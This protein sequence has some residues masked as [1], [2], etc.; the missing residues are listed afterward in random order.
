MV[1]GQ[2]FYHGTS[3]RGLKTIEPP[4]KTGVIQEISRKKNLNRVFFTAD[5]KMASIYAGRAARVYG[6]KG[7]SYT[8]K[9]VYEVELTTSDMEVVSDIKG[10]SVYMSEAPLKVVKANYL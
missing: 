7:N 4:S 1:V 6:E 2:K 5:Y 3:I 10:A 9:V 8:T